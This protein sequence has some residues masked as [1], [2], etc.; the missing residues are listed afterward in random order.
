MKSISKLKIFSDNASGAAFSVMLRIVIII[1]LAG[2][3]C[4][5]LAAGLTMMCNSIKGGYHADYRPDS[6]KHVFVGNSGK[7]NL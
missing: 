4:I 7:K 1:A 3:I 5:L 2:G 6:G